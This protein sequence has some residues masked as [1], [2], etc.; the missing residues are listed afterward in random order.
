MESLEE[1]T[2]T[3]PTVGDR[4][5]TRRIRLRDG[6]EHGGDLG[7]VVAGPEPFELRPPHLRDRVPGLFAVAIAGTDELRGVA[8]ELLEVVERAPSPE[9]GLARA[10][11]EL[12]RIAK[13]ARKRDW[14]TRRIA[15]PTKP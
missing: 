1:L 2:K 8:A 13:A 9:A 3:S 15:A 6:R 11:E 14:V 5:R 10:T 7:T 12:T 4:V